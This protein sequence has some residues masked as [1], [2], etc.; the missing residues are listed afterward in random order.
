[1]LTG[2]VAG[3][4]WAVSGLLKARMGVNEILSTVM[5]N[6]IA[7]QLMNFLAALANA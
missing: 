1:M 7:L 2:A 3:L 5:M 4:I 6:Q